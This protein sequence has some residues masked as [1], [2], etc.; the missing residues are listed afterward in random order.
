MG[1]GE[2]PHLK[3]PSP[4]AIFQ[5]TA[6]QFVGRGVKPEQTRCALIMVRALSTYRTARA[7]LGERPVAGEVC[8][9]WGGP[10]A[11]WRSA[12]AQR[13]LVNIE[14]D[15]VCT[16]A[17]RAS[18]SPSRSCWAKN[19]SSS[20]SSASSRSCCRSRRAVS[21]RSFSF[22]SSPSCR[23]SIAAA[24]SSPKSSGTMSLS[25][26][27]RPRSSA[28]DMACRIV[29]SRASASV[30]RAL[31]PSARLDTSSPKC[32]SGACRQS[33]MGPRRRETYSS[34]SAGSRS[35]PSC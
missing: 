27:K 31:S 25:A 17:I 5:Q 3:K 10:A 12:L 7:A 35:R 19:R 16:P 21:H 6:L 29:A 22:L 8:A 23:R 15:Q 1:Q 11:Y 32:S 20:F 2:E 30:S 33:E 4:T 26:P 24:S 9:L 13:R 28:L 18:R 14:Y 34:S